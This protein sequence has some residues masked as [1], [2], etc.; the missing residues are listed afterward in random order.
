M[1]PG[2]VHTQMTGTFLD[3]EMPPR[4]HQSVQ[5]SGPRDPSHVIRDLEMENTQKRLEG[6]SA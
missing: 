1:T 6:M 5:A 3:P 4:P 2:H